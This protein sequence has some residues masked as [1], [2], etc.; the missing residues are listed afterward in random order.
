MA[1]GVMKFSTPPS[2]LLNYLQN[3]GITGSDYTRKV[4]HF[5][6]THKKRIF[7]LKNPAG[8]TWSIGDLDD[9]IYRGKENELNGWGKFYLPNIVHMQVVGVVE[10]FSCLC[11]QLILM[12]CEDK[13][14]YAYDGEELHVVAS[15]LEQLF[16][17]GI[18]YPSSKSYYYGEA[19]KDMTVN[20]WDKVKKGAVGK[21]LDQA[22]QKLVTAEKSR[23][24]QALKST[25]SCPGVAS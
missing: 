4:S 2:D 10:G 9:T 12:T 3:N 8:A 15:S 1:C 20:D 11:D 18:E 7:S 22:H 24:L 6:S 14:M 5:V 23:F 17:E 19:F 13:K 25:I 16:K 21:S